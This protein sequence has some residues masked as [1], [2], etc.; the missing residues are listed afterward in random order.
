MKRFKYVCV[1]AAILGS[2]VAV[3]LKPA[4]ALS[5][6]GTDPWGGTGCVTSSVV[7][8][9]TPYYSSGGTYQGGAIRLW[10]SSGCGTAWTNTTEPSG[11][12]SCAYPLAKTRR[13][14]QP[15]EVFETGTMASN[16]SDS[17]SRQVYDTGYWSGG[18]YYPRLAVGFA[19]MYYNCAPVFYY[20]L[21]VTD[22]F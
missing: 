16:N 18:T 15:G 22:P 5:Y 3:G 6:D 7:K 19:Y 9:S 11:Q 14:M 10:Y 12:S 1:L 13:T 8:K 20:W 4:G 17:F 2:S 21:T